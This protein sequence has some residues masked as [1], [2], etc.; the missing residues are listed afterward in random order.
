MAAIIEKLH[1]KVDR[2]VIVD[3]KENIYFAVI[4]MQRDG[5][6]IEVDSRPSDA[7]ALAMRLRVPIYVS[8][9]LEDKFVDEFEEILSKVEPG[10][11]VH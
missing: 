10:E 7:I 6:E 5:T 3:L 8:P 2:V 11:T 1:A 4:Y 9:K